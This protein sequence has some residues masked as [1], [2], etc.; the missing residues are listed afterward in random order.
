MFQKFEIRGV[1]TDIDSKLQAY[2]TKKI[3]SLD[4]YVSRH[5]RASARAEVHLKNNQLKGAQNSRCEIKVSLPK[6]TIIIKED[7]INMYAAVDIA[8]AKL[9]QQLQKYKEL[10]N[11]GKIRGQLVSRIRGEET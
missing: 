9:K 11:R 10:H 7:G 2:V 5:A 3:G 1:H 6:E 4:R 8:E